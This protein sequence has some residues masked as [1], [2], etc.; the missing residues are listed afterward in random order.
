MQAPPGTFRYQLP[1]T[2]GHETAGTVAAL[3]PGASG[4]GAG[5]PG[6]SGPGAGGLSVGDQVLVYARWGC[7]ACW[8]CLQGMENLCQ[9]T[10]ELG[11]HGA[12]VGR[13]GGLAEYLIVPSPRYLLPIAGL[14]PVLAAPLSDAALTPYHAIRRARDQLVP[15]AAVVVIGA[16]GLG[17][18][19]IQLLRALSATRVIAVD[20]RPAARELALAAGA[21]AA[22]TP[23]ECAHGRLRAEA[24]PLGAA[25]VL[26]CVGSD[27]TL[28]LAATV[29]APGGVISYLGRGGGTLPVTPARLPF[30][31]SVV[32]PTWGTLPELAEVIELARAGAIRPEVERFTLDEAGAAY[33]RLR[34]GTLRGRAVVVP[35]S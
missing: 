14:D 11:S 5:G 8:H 25:L 17:H 22:L 35:P 2:L 33:R 1:F 15:G 3:G 9:R 28:D 16:G 21:H 24:G 32:I 6:A 23:D 29:V 26:D 10:A 12:G 31:S 19:A 4:L 20:I 13:D 18:L 30:E 27:A 7:S 34:E